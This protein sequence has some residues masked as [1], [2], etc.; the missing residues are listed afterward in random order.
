M[1]Y[2]VTKQKSFDSVL[3]WMDDLKAQAEPNLII[4]LVGNKIDL[5]QGNTSIQRVPT[6]DGKRL[7]MEYN[8]LFEETSALTSLNVTNAFERLLEGGN[9]FHTKIF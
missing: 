7:A 9:S 4:M 8:M 6:E 3:R 5:C 1:V 2:D